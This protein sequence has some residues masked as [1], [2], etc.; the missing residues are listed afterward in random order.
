[1]CGGAGGLLSDPYLYANKWTIMTTYC[2]GPAGMGIRQD[3]E[4]VASGAFGIGG[5]TPNVAQMGPFS[6]GGYG[7]PDNPY[8]AYMGE[9]L[10]YNRSLSNS[11]INQVEQYLSQRWSI[12]LVGSHAPSFT[13]ADG[14]SCADA[15]CSI[16]GNLSVNV[17][18]I[19]P[20]DC[21]CIAG[22]PTESLTLTPY[23]PEMSCEGS[24]PWVS[25][26]YWGTY[27]SA[28]IYWNYSQSCWI[29]DISCCSSWY[30]GPYGNSCKGFFNVWTGTKGGSSPRGT[31]T[32][33]SHYWGTGCGLKTTG[34][35]TVS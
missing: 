28:R 6:N 5:S 9:V 22:V 8:P 26:D 17:S 13:P 18:G 14:S 11:E 20:G 10:M 3:G 34:T 1:M 35:I 15:S 21:G 31:Y 25:Y 16:T 33:T 32:M 4:L 27:H 24:Y 7:D 29:L 2:G 19:G 23:D 12:A 30:E